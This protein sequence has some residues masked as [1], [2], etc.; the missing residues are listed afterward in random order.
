MKILWVTNIP[1][2]EASLLMGEKPIPFG[3]WLINAASGLKRGNIKLEI[4]FP[5]ISLDKVEVLNGKD[6]KFYIFP[7]VNYS[8]L[9]MINENPYLYNIINKSNP[10]I[11]HI[12]GTEFPHTLAMVNIC[13]KKNIDV[14]ISMQGLVSFIAKHYMNGLPERV[15]KLFT[16]RDLIKRDNIKMQQK[17]FVKRGE[18]EIKAL[19]KVSHVIGRTTWDYA[20]AT[21]I[22]PNVIY[23]YCN[24]TLRDE[25]YTKS[26]TKENCEQ[27]SIFVS[28]GSYPIKGLHFMLEAMPIILKSFPMAKLYIAGSDF[29]KFDSLKQKLTI[30]SYGKYINELLK[31][32]N[33]QEKVVFIGELDEKHM[34]QRFLNSNVFVCPSTIENS[35]NSLGEAMILG[36]PTVAA[37][38]GGITDLLK[39]KEEGFVYQAD[40]PYML[41]H[42]I[43]EVFKNEQLALDFSKKAKIK[44]CRL[45]DKEQ[46]NK[47]LLE[48]YWHIN[49]GHRV[50]LEQS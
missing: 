36:V 39:H 10:D 32:Y 47:R 42:Y 20:C 23:H 22:N 11:V 1:L 45:H 25:F 3:G 34:C 35:P 31:K 19:Q 13:I 7:S 6:I 30:T 29:T 28:Q 27:F 26:W 46:N 14:V 9:A 12:F 48:I 49:S 33:L 15:Q 38:V 17:K 50:T 8:N 44:A 37:D 4:A 24:E 2:P 21:I 41:A 18:F 43:C 5:K 16:F 40:A